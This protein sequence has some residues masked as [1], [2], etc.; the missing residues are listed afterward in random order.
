MGDQ[1][2]TNQLDQS[3]YFQSSYPVAVSTNNSNQEGYTVLIPANVYVDGGV[4]VNLDPEVEQETISVGVSQKPKEPESIISSRTKETS[5]KSNQKD[6]VLLERIVRVAA[7]Q[8]DRDLVISP[9]S[10]A[11]SSRMD[12]CSS[13]EKE[14]TSGLSYKNGSSE[15]TISEHQNDL[16]SSTVDASPICDTSSSVFGSQ[17]IVNVVEGQTS[18]AS[19]APSVYG[20]DQHPSSSSGFA[21]EPISSFDD[22]SNGD[23]RASGSDISGQ[24]MTPSSNERAS[25]SLHPKRRRDKSTAPSRFCEQVDPG[26]KGH[27][28]QRAILNYRYCIRHILLDPEAPYRRCQHKRKPKSKKDKNLY[29]TNAIKNTE[30]SIYCSTH[31]IMKGMKE[32]KKKKSLLTQVDDKIESETH[33]VNW[34]DESAQGSSNQPTTS[35]PSIEN[36]GFEQTRYNEVQCWRGENINDLQHVEEVAKLPQETFNSQQTFVNSYR[37]EVVQ[38]SF[39]RTSKPTSNLPPVFEEPSNL[40]NSSQVV[41]DE[42]SCSSMSSP[43]SQKPVM[44]CD[45]QPPLV[46]SHSL[47]PRVQVYSST[48]APSLSKQHP[49]LL[50]KLLVSSSTPQAHQPVFPVPSSM[51]AQQSVISSPKF[52]VQVA[53]APPNASL[54]FSPVLRVPS[55]P[56]KKYY[57][58]EGLDNDNDGADDDEDEYGDEKPGFSQR[59]VKPALIQLKQKHHRTNMLGLYR[60]IPCVNR[61]CEVLDEYDYDNMD[62]FPCGLEPSDDEDSDNEMERESSALKRQTCENTENTAPEVYLLKKRLRLDRCLLTKEAQIN[63]FVTMAAKRFP[64]SVGL[65]LSHRSSRSCSFLRNRSRR[66]CYIFSDG[67]TRCSENAIPMSNHCKKHALYNIDQKLFS[68]CMETC[69]N[70]PVLCVDGL[71][72]N[73]LC[74]HHY[75]LSLCHVDM[76]G[77]ATEDITRGDASLLPLNSLND[78]SMGSGGALSSFSFINNDPMVLSYNDNFNALDQRSDFGQSTDLG[79]TEV[80]DVEMF[81]SVAKDFGF[82]DVDAMLAGIHSEGE[83]PSILLHNR[84][85]GNK[86]NDNLVLGSY[87]IMSDPHD[88]EFWED[89]AQIMRSDGFSANSL[90][91]PMYSTGTPSPMMPHS[92]NSSAS[93]YNPS[94][95]PAQSSGS[96]PQPIPAACSLLS[97]RS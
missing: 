94:P 71:L 47:Q 12:A 87:G 95:S 74:R 50:A 21:D 44:L 75:E 3:N 90:T 4:N 36:C 30:T 33:N 19:T 31:M 69:C 88:G 16:C 86:A 64:N 52:H 60:S 77:S 63:A 9:D 8:S 61:L 57:S 28:R 48:Q 91:P 80:S 25:P 93:S 49:Q 56:I 37:P 24:P 79:D 20:D 40:G 85:S 84:S 45:Q 2:V 43:L 26:G 51:C 68:Y 5:L 7:S 32:P 23:T 11:D 6:K 41:V 82:A 62:L 34:N 39:T 76:I 54:S 67:C 38:R 1:M 42:S 10:F 17:H 97:R 83:D 18:S 15:K 78:S 13:H 96:H 66:C 65:A 22:P 92:S 89:V 14:A 53:S 27:C 58:L 73:G 72:T 55:F 46:S 70:E 59:S 35:L 29:C 81:D